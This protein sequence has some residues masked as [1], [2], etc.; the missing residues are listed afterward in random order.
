MQVFFVVLSGQTHRFKIRLKKQKNAASKLIKIKKIENGNKNNFQNKELRMLL[1]KQT[2][3]RHNKMRV[4][5]NRT[6]LAER[7]II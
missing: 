3:K 2:N 1:K 6:L 4:W 7:F 5:L